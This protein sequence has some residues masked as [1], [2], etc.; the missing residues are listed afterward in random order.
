M[1]EILISTTNDSLRYKKDCKDFEC[2]K[3]GTLTGDERYCE[4]SH[5]CQ[6]RGFRNGKS[7]GMLLGI[8][9]IKDIVTGEVIEHLPFC[10]G[11]HDLRTID[12]KFT[13]SII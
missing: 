5:R 2:L 8:L 11:I 4:K 7:V 3:D 12:K 13:D 10:T 1:S 6:Q 9:I